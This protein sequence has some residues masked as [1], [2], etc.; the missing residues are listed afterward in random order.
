MSELKP[1]PFCEG[2]SVD[3]KNWCYVSLNERSGDPK[4]KRD[5]AITNEDVEKAFNKRPIEEF[6]R[7]RI[8]ELESEVVILMHRE[9]KLRSEQG[10]IKA[11]AVREWADQAQPNNESEDRMVNDAYDY[12]TKLEKG[13]V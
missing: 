9:R 1:C 6:L 3:H 5:L 12:A 7:D 13:E 10:I 8:S 11:K 4:T 2:S